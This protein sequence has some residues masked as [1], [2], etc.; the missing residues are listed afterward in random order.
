[1]SELRDWETLENGFCKF[2]KNFFFFLASKAKQI[3]KKFLFSQMIS[4]QKAEVLKTCCLVFVL[5]LFLSLAVFFYYTCDKFFLIN[6]NYHQQ[7]FH[8]PNNQ[9]NPPLIYSSQIPAPHG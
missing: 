3:K 8:Y 2:F 1:M 7:T 5:F 9:E 4:Q 6:L